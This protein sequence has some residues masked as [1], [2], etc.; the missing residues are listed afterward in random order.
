MSGL[1]VSDLS[2]R[3]GGIVALDGVSFTVAPGE[4]V[5]LIGPN[6]AGQTTVFHC[7]TRLYTPDRGAISFDG[8][9]LLRLPTHR[10]VHCGIAR[11]FQHLELFPTMTVGEVLLV[12]EHGRSRA[13]V[14]STAL[15]LPHVRREERELRARIADILDLLELTPYRDVPCGTLPFGVQKRVDLGRALATRPR[16]LL[17]DEPA[18]GLN[19]EELDELGRLIRRIRDERG[20]AILLVEHHMALVMSIS[21]RVTVLDFGRKIAE[22]TPAEVRANPAVIEA[23]LGEE[24][25]DA[26]AG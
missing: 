4:I 24:V 6:G 19:H 10:I 1:V 12:G 23:Y 18:G 17:L 14:V 9:D 13:D 5:G 21:D 20:I 25:V 2:I 15:W 3:F 26:P 7:I 8:V 16:L 22:G 11:T